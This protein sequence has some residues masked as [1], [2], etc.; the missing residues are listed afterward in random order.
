MTAVLVAAMVLAL[1]A[2]ALL[3]LV[4]ALSSAGL[5]HRLALVHALG[6]AL[7]MLFRARLA[8]GGVFRLGAHLLAHAGAAVG[9]V[10]T[11]RVRAL[12]VLAHLMLVL[13]ALAVGLGRRRLGVG[14]ERAGQQGGSDG[15]E[16]AGADQGLDPLEVNHESFSAHLSH[17][18][19]ALR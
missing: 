17:P 9:L 4:A 5:V 3:Q 14:E 16:D 1:R 19:V 6:V 18:L 10:L 8:L 15:G 13:A 11:G 7:A 2:Q 12:H